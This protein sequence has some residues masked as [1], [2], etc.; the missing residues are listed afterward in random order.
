MLFVKNLSIFLIWLIFLDQGAGKECNSHPMWIEGFFWNIFSCS[1]SSCLFF[2]RLVGTYNF[3]R[4]R[5]NGL[6]KLFSFQV[7]VILAIVS[8]LINKA[9]SNVF[10]F[11]Q[12]C[13]CSVIVV[14]SVIQ[15]SASRSLVPKINYL[16]HGR[17][18]KLQKEIAY[19]T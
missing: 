11:L 16:Q 1:Y 15:K 6:R 19:S 4:N 14:I 2:T 3:M 17:I 8:Q 5:W 7:W 18:L 10:F 13:Q 12:I 9:N